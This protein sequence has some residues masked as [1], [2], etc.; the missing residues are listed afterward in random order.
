MRKRISEEQK[1]AGLKILNKSIQETERVRNVAANSR[2]ILDD[3]DR[4]FA[5]VTKLD[6]VDFSFLFFATALQTL[7]W[8]LSPRIGESFDPDDRKKE[9]DKSIKDDIKYNNKDYQKKHGGWD[10]G[11]SGK[12]YKDWQNI[13]FSK[14]P[15]DTISG[16]KQFGLELSGL[17]HRYKTLGHDPM[18]GWIFGTINIMTDT[19]TMNT[20]RTFDIEKG[21]FVSET[22]LGHAINDFICS[23]KEDWHRVPAAVF[24]EGVHLKSDEFTKIGLPVPLV[25]VFSEELAKALCKNNY[26]KLCL[27]K[28]VK[29]IG[30]QAAFSILINMII[31]AVHGLFYDEKKHTSHQLYE[32]KTRK[33]LMYS[34]A[35]SSSSNLIYVAVESYLRDKTAW[36][37]LDIGGLAEA[38]HQIVS[39]VDFIYKIKEEFITNG[40]DKLISENDDGRMDN[41]SK[42]EKIA[43]LCDGFIGWIIYRMGK[44]D[45]VK[46]G[47]A[48]ASDK[49]EEKLREERDI[50]KQLRRVVFGEY[51]PFICPDG[52]DDAFWNSKI[53]Q[54][55]RKLDQAGNL[56]PSE[57]IAEFID[58]LL[59]DLDPNE[60]A[61]SRRQLGVIRKVVFADRKIKMEI[62][63]AD[64]KLAID[65][66]DRYIDPKNLKEANQYL[67]IKE[68]AENESELKEVRR[69]LLKLRT[70]ILASLEG[71]SG[72]NILVLGKTG[73]GKSSLLNY[74]VGSNVSEVGTGRSVTKKGIFKKEA[75]IGDLIVNIY[76]SWGIEAGDKFE[77][78]EGLIRR[79]KEKHDATRDPSE[80][81]HVIVYCIQAGGHRI[82]DIDINIIN[83]FCEER[84]CLIP[85]LTKAD[86]CSPADEEKMRKTLS[87]QCKID[88]SSIVAVCS[89]KKELRCGGGS[90]PFGGKELKKAIRNGYCETLV[91]FLPKRFIYLAIGEINRFREKVQ[92]EISWKAKAFCSDD[93]CKRWLDKETRGF[94]KQFQEVD[95]PRIMQQEIEKAVKTGKILSALIGY[96]K[97][98]LF[99]PSE[100]F[101]DPC[102]PFWMKALKTLFASIV[103]APAAIYVV[104]RELIAGKKGRQTEL[105]AALNKFCN[106]LIKIVEKQEE[107]FRAQVEG[108]F[109]SPDA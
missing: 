102:D 17:N 64:R 22:T 63:E 59:E 80:W 30:Q 38:L 92:G 66:L 16:A 105:E 75:Q 56:T 45:G 89:E 93:E 109:L 78:W 31:S 99:D 37:K 86:L 47:Y 62:E 18:L 46:K 55:V 52:W 67:G 29:T 5:E 3:L 51:N 76:D 71:V 7:R 20:F 4:Q 57:I 9:N 10:S 11:E 73:T 6:K 21:R 61:E 100:P 70:E 32:V 81:F 87:E 79:E 48:K 108:I 42:R 77:E 54:F 8:V 74:L 25:S 84:Y 43:I 2:Q 85:V 19:A 97:D 39:D 41:M 15:F 98:S 72:C 104:L 40:F 101:F 36:Q 26:D 28:D 96:D 91:G 14:P 107:G 23:A 12:G 50:N 106:D 1:A 24:A 103:A 60:F 58:S 34:N 68:N 82:E 49:Y 83:D 90:D 94:A 35:I 65:F 33:I 13:I 95:L 88:E 27:I 69:E 53:E 44:V